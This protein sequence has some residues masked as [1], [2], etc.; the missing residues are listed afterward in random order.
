M[1][2]KRRY[3]IGIDPGAKGGLAILDHHSGDLTLERLVSDL[4]GMYRQ[5]EALSGCPGTRVYVENVG[6]GRPGNAIKA[7]TTFARHCGHLDAYLSL[8]Y[9]GT[10][11]D[12]YGQQVCSVSPMRWMNKVV[13]RDRPKVVSDR[14]AYIMATVSGILIEEFGAYQGPLNLDTADAAGI[15]IYGLRDQEGAYA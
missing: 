6:S 4:P 13:G 1:S 15:L 10:V 7:M 3:T 2:R 11:K 12:R 14:K 8:L 9:P 5:L